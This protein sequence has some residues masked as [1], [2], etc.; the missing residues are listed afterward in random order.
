MR[1]KKAYLYCLYTVLLLAAVALAAGV[2][3]RHE[4]NFYRTQDIEPGAGRKQLSAKFMV[5]FTQ[6]GLNVRHGDPNWHFIF[7]DAEVNSFFQ[8]DFV[9]SGEE[10]KLRKVGITEPRIAFEDDCIRI[11]F[12]YG[13]GTWSTIVSYDLRVWA[14]PKEPNVLAVEIRGRRMGALPVSS[15]ALLDDLVELARSHNIDVTRYR[16]EGNP[17]ALIRFPSDQNH[18]PPQLK[19]LRV[20]VGALHIGGSCPNGRNA[21]AKALAPAGN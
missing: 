7:S 6:L 10:E 20:A 15:Q 8:E 2:V 5:D 12:R 16:Y 19:C 9:A 11:A 1:N 13:S 3:L 14:V 18:P 21:A 17:V 4:P